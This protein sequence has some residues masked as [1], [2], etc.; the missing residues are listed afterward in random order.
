MSS[1]TQIAFIV[2]DTFIGIILITFIG[3]CC[4]VE[5]CTIIRENWNGT[6]ASIDLEN[7]R[8]NQDVEE[9]EMEHLPSRHLKIPE[10]S[11]SRPRICCSPLQVEVSQSD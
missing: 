5:I 9:I 7:N 6:W 4:A 11:E 3:V 2:I 1:I 8:V 10:S